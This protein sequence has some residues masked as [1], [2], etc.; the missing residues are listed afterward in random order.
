MNSDLIH[1][2]A[3][4]FG[5]SE[6][7]LLPDATL[8]SLGLDSLAVIEFLFQIEDQFGIQIPDQANPPR[9][10]GEMVQLIEPLL[11]ADTSAGKPAAA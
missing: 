3:E 4:T 8:E 10:L 2:F 1:L 7:K 9:T 5:I 6:E 11:P